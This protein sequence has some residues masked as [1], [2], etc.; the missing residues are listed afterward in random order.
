MP[1]NSKLILFA[2]TILAVFGYFVY[3]SYLSKTE[4]NNHIS[5][6]N[7]NHRAFDL[8]KAKMKDAIPLNDD[9]IKHRDLKK[10]DTVFQTASSATVEQ[11]EEAVIIHTENDTKDR[12]LPPGMIKEHIPGEYLDNM[13][14]FYARLNEIETGELDE[15]EN[16]EADPIFFSTLTPDLQFGLPYLAQTFSPYSI[17]IFATF[18]SMT[19]NMRNKSD[20]LVKWHNSNDELILF[21]YLNIIPNANFNY[22]WKELDYWNTG[23]YNV[24]IYTLKENVKV[25]ASGSFFVENLGNY[26]SYLGI[27]P[28]P[29]I[30]YPE[31]TFYSDDEIYLVFNHSN[32]T[33]RYL[34]LY[35][36]TIESGDSFIDKDILLPI[37]QDKIFKLTIKKS[38]DLIPTGAYRLEL[39]DDNHLVGRS[40]FYIAE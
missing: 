28:S 9:K 11:E 22:V 18:E 34:R 3:T 32:E 8:R 15:N 25:L 23:I 5:L 6:P 19:E 39:V 7:Q 14:W 37:S 10:Q 21:E 20:V 17:R 24:E 27:Y 33:E 31:S 36:Y 40:R 30:A 26:V 12:Y 16:E 29:E 13:D 2:I 35:V 1:K 4:K 38:G